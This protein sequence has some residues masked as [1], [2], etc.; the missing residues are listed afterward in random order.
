MK[1]NLWSVIIAL[2]FFGM[3]GS[4]SSCGC[5]DEI[6]EAATVEKEV[7]LPSQNVP[8]DMTDVPYPETG[9][10]K[11]V[12]K[13]ERDILTLGPIDVPLADAIDKA[14]ELAGQSGTGDSIEEKLE[15]LDKVIISKVVFDIKENTVTQPGLAIYL[16]IS[17]YGDH[18]VDNSVQLVSIPSIEPGKVTKV[19]IETPE[20]EQ[21]KQGEILRSGQFTLW[22]QVKFFVDTEK[23][24]NPPEGKVD[25]DVTMVAKFIVK[26]LEGEL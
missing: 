25:I 13:E 3:L 12:V 10:G 1:W 23:Y 16:R 15:K 8:V 19:T 20:E 22:I 7:E 24:P 18:D 6:E 4:M 21:D 14:L 2:A 17:E 11:P 5:E 9:E 26:L